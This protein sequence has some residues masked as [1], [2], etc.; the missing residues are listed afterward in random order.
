VVAEDGG[1]A[2]F[3]CLRFAPDKP[4]RRTSGSQTD[5]FDSDQLY[6][7]IALYPDR[8]VGFTRQPDQLF[9]GLGAPQELGALL[10]PDPGHVM[11]EH[12]R[13][14]AWHN[15]ARARRVAGQL[16]EGQAEEKRHTGAGQI[17]LPA[18]NLGGVGKREEA[19]GASP[20][21]IQTRASIPAFFKSRSRHCQAMTAR[22]NQ[23]HGHNSRE[24]LRGQVIQKGAWSEML[25]KRNEYDL[26]A[27]MAAT[28]KAVSAS[29]GIQRGTDDRHADRGVV[30]RK[31]GSRI[32]ADSFERSAKT[33]RTRPAVRHNQAV[34]RP[35]ACNQHSTAPIPKK[36]WN[37]SVMP[38]TT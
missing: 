24:K 18:G 37:G 7:R 5:G 31:N 13:N 28:P 14:Q 16:R 22:A 10:D 29:N 6:P 34:R 35:S 20:R 9:G 36:N 11:D 38:I 27:T 33:K 8:A 19:I 30:S 17:G 3:L 15:D 25:L 26:V 23:P 32:I 12:H 21:P 2:A 1:R 4:G